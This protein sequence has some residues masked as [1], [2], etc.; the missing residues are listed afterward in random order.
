MSDWLIVR[1][2]F[3]DPQN[4]EIIEVLSNVPINWKDY[5]EKVAKKQKSLEDI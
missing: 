4:P 2:P 5:L 1:I 3:D